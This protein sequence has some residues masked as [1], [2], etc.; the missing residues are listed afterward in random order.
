[1]SKVVGHGLWD[2]QI[3]TRGSKASVRAG[4]DG[5][6]NSLRPGTVSRDQNGFLSTSILIFAI[7]ST[8]F[9]GIEP[10]LD[11]ESFF[12]LLVWIEIPISIDALGY[13]RRSVYLPIWIA[14]DNNFDAG[15]A[16][17]GNKPSFDRITEDKKT[18]R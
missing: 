14:V 13:V 10:A 5:D 2:G 3:G 8:I 11:V 12:F 9:F 15:N 16:L 4:S 17:D 1:M 6:T 18:A 7:G